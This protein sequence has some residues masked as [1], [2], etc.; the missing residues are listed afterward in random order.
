[1]N[2]QLDSK[3][4]I[5]AFSQQKISARNAQVKNSKT[6]QGAEANY[7]SLICTSWF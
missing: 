7:K 5:C 6:M 4:Y 1:M 2:S 3:I